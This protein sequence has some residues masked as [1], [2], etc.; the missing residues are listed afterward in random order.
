VVYIYS[1]K[2]KLHKI[3]ICTSG[4]WAMRRSVSAVSAVRQHCVNTNRYNTQHTSYTPCI[5]LKRTANNKLHAAQ[6]FWRCQQ[7]HRQSA[8]TKLEGSLPCK[9]QPSTCSYP[10]QNETNNVPRPPIYLISFFNIIL[11]STP[12]SLNWFPSLTLSSQDK[13]LVFQTRFM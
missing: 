2:E 4:M 3:F 7:R 6:C 8:D 11:P 1:C 10:E 5:S 12:T 13:Q 9:Q